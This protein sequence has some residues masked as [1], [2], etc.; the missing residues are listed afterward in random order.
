MKRVFSMV[1]FVAT[2]F[3]GSTVFAANQQAGSAYFPLTNPK[4][5]ARGDGLFLNKSHNIP[6]LIGNGDG[7]TVIGPTYRETFAYG[8]GDGITCETKRRISATGAAADVECS[9]TCEALTPPAACIAAYDDALA[10]AGDIHTCIHTD[11]DMCHCMSPGFSHGDCALA[12]GTSDAFYHENSTIFTVTTGNGLVLGY[13]P[14][15][16]QTI[17][18]DMD[19]DSLD[20][21]H[22][23]T[24]NDGFE[25]FSGG[26]WGTS[27]RPFIVGED[28]AF[29][30]C[31]D[32]EFAVAVASTDDFHMGFREAEEFN[33]TFD[34]YTDFATI[35]LITTNFTIETALAN[36][37]TVTTD[38][39]QD[40]VNATRY[41]LCTKVSDAGVVTYTINGQA[42][43]TTAAYTFTDG[44][45]V[46]P[47]VHML[48]AAT[49][50]GEVD[51]RLWEVKYQ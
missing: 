10:N 2:L 47:F 34:D 5:Y 22:D 36:A 49:L 40:A 16:V 45:P 12:V 28:P 1:A 35:G 13:A 32:V 29:Q 24:D 30:F 42:P 33:V 51:L 15:I 11:A 46:I 18:P 6:V 19:A 8:D 41:V 44:L 25:Y 21:G 4:S 3:C 9:D 38:T 39:T 37:G 43:A 31:I 50:T 20:I 27:G 7:Y 17:G 23:Q 14:I 26:P 48:Q